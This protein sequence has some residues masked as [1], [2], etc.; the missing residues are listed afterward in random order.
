M[1]LKGF[2][3]LQLLFKKIKY[4]HECIHIEFGDNWL[5]ITYRWIHFILFSLIH[6]S[7]PDDYF[8]CQL[9]R[10][11][12]FEIKTYIT[13]F[14][15]I[16]IRRK[17]NKG[18]SKI[19]NNK[20]NFNN[21]YGYMLKR[22]WLDGDNCTFEEF[23]NFVYNNNKYIVKPKEGNGGKGITIK[24]FQNDF[25][26]EYNNISGM[27]LEEIIEQH[28]QLKKL[29]P[30]S[31]NTIRFAV[32]QH[33]DKVNIISAT[34]RC[35]RDEECVDNISHGG[36]GASIDIDTGVVFTRGKTYRNEFFLKH[37]LTN[38]IFV[39]FKIPMWEE[40]IL[41]VKE[42]TKEIN[43]LNWI[44]WD[45]AITPK[46]PCVVEGNHNGAQTTMQAFDNIGKYTLVKKIM[47]S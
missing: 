25:P 8:K 9:Y 7:G 13:L 21:N 22:S 14:K 20:V 3:M 46:G 38:T 6:L 29:N 28:A 15:L 4:V 5:K 41:F 23:K 34:L 19:L 26:V 27:I 35:S 32:L 36:I 10:K 47:K 1:D 39:G 45:I 40:T 12:T 42:I 2:K 16:R 30:Y 44:S 17:Y 31:V 24:S 33:K 18:D 37:P 11:S 43:G